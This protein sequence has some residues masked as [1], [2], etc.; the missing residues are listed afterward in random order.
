MSE[1]IFEIYSEEVPAKLQEPAQEQ[2]KALFQK[3]ADLHSVTYEV[4][5]TFST[6]NRLV[7]Y[8]T[9]LPSI[10]KK[11]AKELKGPLANAPDQAIDGFCKKNNLTKADLFEKEIQDKIYYCANIA[12]PPSSIYNIMPDIIMAI[13]TSFKWPKTMRWPESP[14]R[15]VRPIRNLLCMVD[16][17]SIPIEFGGCRNFIKEEQRQFDWNEFKAFEKEWLTYWEVELS[18]EEGKPR[19]LIGRGVYEEASSKY[20]PDWDAFTLIGETAT[21]DNFDKHLSWAKKIINL[22]EGEF[23]I[24]LIVGEKEYNFEPKKKK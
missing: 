19:T 3:N 11:P 12:E 7:L 5:K 17:V 24:K 6:P 2:L 21:A 23:P 10:I 15:W 14:D 9:G 8:V 22:Y 20:S 16:D 18:T 4:V 13:L 1:L